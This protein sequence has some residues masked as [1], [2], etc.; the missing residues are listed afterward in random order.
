[1]ELIHLQET[2]SEGLSLYYNRYLGDISKLE[3]RISNIDR[4]VEEILFPSYSISRETETEWMLKFGR[5]SKQGSGGQRNKEEK[6]PRNSN[7]DEYYADYAGHE[8]AE[9]IVSP[10]TMPPYLMPSAM[11]TNPLG[12]EANNNNLARPIT[13]C[14]RQSGSSSRK[15]LPPLFFYI[16][17]GDFRRAMER[18]QRHPREVKT[19]ASIKIKSSSA[20]TTKRLA[21]HQACFKVGTHNPWS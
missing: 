21:L 10:M 8:A 11:S 3:D 4:T 16:E 15:T 2:T 7:Q 14:R 12:A 13:S 6:N 5:K 17:A 19:W 20:D 18:A 1:M 9:D